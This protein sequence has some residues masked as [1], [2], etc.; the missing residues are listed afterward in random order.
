LGIILLGVPL[1]S[2]Q[3]LVHDLSGCRNKAD[4]QPPGLLLDE[5]LQLGEP[6][7]D[8]FRDVW[9]RDDIHVGEL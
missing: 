6:R 1:K 7:A 8:S 4:V 5:F 9:Q 2:V 3:H